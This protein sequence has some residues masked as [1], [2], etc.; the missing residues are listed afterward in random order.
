MVKIV[1]EYSQMYEK[2]IIMKMQC[3]LLVSYVRRTMIFKCFA[4]KMIL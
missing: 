3:D 4:I 1:L 2:K